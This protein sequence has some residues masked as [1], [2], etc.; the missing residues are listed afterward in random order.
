MSSLSFE[1]TSSRMYVLF[2]EAA[3]I[4]AFQLPDWSL[5]AE[6]S[7]PGGASAVASGVRWDGVDVT[8]LTAGPTPGPTGFSMVLAMRVSLTT[9]ATS[10]FKP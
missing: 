6:W 7:T 10:Y 3:K 9:Q 4:R 2:P 5:V 8:V 1:A